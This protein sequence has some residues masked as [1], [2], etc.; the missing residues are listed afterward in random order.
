[1]LSS[2]RGKFIVIFLVVTTTAVVI[3]SGHARLMQRKYT[4]E[5]AEVRCRENLQLMNNE[6]STV[7]QW[8]VRDLF[9]LRDLPQMNSFLSTDNQL[10]KLDSFRAIEASFL[11]VAKNHPIFHQIRLIDVHGQEIIRVNFKDGKAKLVPPENLQYKGHRYYVKESLVLN[12][13]QIYISPFDLN[14]EHGKLEK[15]YQSVIRY[16]TPIIDKDGH[17]HG[18]IVLNVQ[19][20]AL[21]QILENRQKKSHPGEQHFL[22]DSDGYYL[23][24]PEVEKRFSNF[25]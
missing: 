7:L 19:G 22:I 10:H 4:L 23:F 13:G 2:L 25:F 16:A 12:S 15:P 18:S 24:H 8:V 20:T 3:S 11:A 21:L 1:M 9:L 14:M 17:P 5:R 6:I